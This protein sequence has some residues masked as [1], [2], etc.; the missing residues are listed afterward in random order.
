MPDVL[1]PIVFAAEPPEEE[2]SQ[3]VGSQAQRVSLSLLW[4]KLQVEIS[5]GGA[6]DA[7]HRREEVSNNV[8]PKL[9]VLMFVLWQEFLAKSGTGVRSK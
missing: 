3:R 7:S 8:D 2:A 1:L 9:K 6:H 5:H 4:Q